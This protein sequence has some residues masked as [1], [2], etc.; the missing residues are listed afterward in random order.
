MPTQLSCIKRLA[1]EPQSTL[2]F[3]CSASLD[4]P[5]HLQLDTLGGYVP[6]TRY[7]Q[8]P[9][10][11]LITIC[12][13]SCEQIAPRLQPKQSP[14]L[15]RHPLPLSVELSRKNAIRRRQRY[16]FCRQ[17]RYPLLARSDHRRR[18]E[19]RRMERN[20]TPT[21]RPSHQQHHIHH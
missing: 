2:C 16:A 19:P 18:H 4:W 12:L 13:Q 17:E 1:M 9:R 7:G 15:Q 14:R 21:P 6:P 11:S 20:A 8:P 10:F 3:L 5:V